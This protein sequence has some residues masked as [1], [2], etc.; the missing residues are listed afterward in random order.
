[1]AEFSATTKKK[2]VECPHCGHEVEVEIR[3]VVIGVAIPDHSPVTDD[4]WRAEL[5]DE[6][7]GVLSYAVEHGV[8]E[9]F[10]LVA[11]RV[12]QPQPRNLERFFLNFMRKA[13]PAS[14]PRPILGKLIA[15]YMD[16]IEC[17]IADGMAMIL[18][19]GMIR[20]FMGQDMLMGKR[21]HGPAGSALKARM[22]ADVGDVDDWIRTRFGYVA[23]SGAM[24]DSM[25]VR[26]HGEFGRG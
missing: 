19:D 8:L 20:C 17:W 11:Q 14:L 9:S 15:A 16:R 26:S 1:M 3:A 12:K 21:V 25:R 22:R 4:A 6:E 23:K 13:V 18:S 10:S 24:F 7:K 5:S 2:R